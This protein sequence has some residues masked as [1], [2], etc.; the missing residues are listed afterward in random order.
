MLLTEE[1]IYFKLFIKSFFLSLYLNQPH[2]DWSIIDIFL[3]ISF[4]FWFGSADGG[5]RTTRFPFELKIILSIVFS[6]GSSFE[7]LVKTYSSL[8]EEAGN[9][10]PF[11][12]SCEPRTI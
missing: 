1:E 10:R 11:N 9:F 4:D 7:K 6:N 8:F 3:K 5:R 12:R 2:E